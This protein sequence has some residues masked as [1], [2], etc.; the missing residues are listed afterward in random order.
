MHPRQLVM[1]DGGGGWAGG[2]ATTSAG[3]SSSVHLRLQKMKAGE[4]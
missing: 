3:S 4:D 1:A 2:C